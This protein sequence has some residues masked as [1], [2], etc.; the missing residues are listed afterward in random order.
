MKKIEATD[1]EL[2]VL[3]TIC[4]WACLHAGGEAAN[5]VAVWQDKIRNAQEIKTKKVTKPKEVK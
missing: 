1:K 2:Q 5:P 4:H 3:A